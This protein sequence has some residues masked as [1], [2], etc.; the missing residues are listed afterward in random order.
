ME[1]GARRPGGAPLLVRV[2][3]KECVATLGFTV[4]GRTATADDQAAC[5]RTPRS[6]T[7]HDGSLFPVCESSRPFGMVD[8]TL[9]STPPRT[10]G[11]VGRTPSRNALGEPR[12]LPWKHIRRGTQIGA[13][14]AHEVR[15][16]W[17]SGICNMDDVVFNDIRRDP[18]QDPHAN[19]DQWVNVRE[20]IFR[21]LKVDELCIA[22]TDAQLLDGVAVASAQR[23]HALG[24]ALLQRPGQGVA[25]ISAKCCH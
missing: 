6:L 3:A 14:A 13:Q 16:W 9:E 22:M 18:V 21:R 2:H 8:L 5:I 10:P 17:R 19:V 24:Y 1:E 4:S 11:I 7:G 23:W 15:W 12:C 25:R 20:G